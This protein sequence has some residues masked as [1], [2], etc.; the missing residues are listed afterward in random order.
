MMKLAIATLFSASAA[1]SSLT[2]DNYGDLING[3]TVFLKFL[4][5]G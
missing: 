3:K 4:H 1:V 2:P 5:L